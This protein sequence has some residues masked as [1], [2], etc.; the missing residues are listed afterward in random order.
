MLFKIVINSQIFLCK[1]TLLQ[2]LQTRKVMVRVNIMWKYAHKKMKYE[3]MH[4][5]RLGE[6]DM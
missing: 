4:R 6:C 5:V 3:M 1:N 2:S